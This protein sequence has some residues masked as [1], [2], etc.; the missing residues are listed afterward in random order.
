MDSIKELFNKNKPEKVS[1]YFS[2]DKLIEEAIERKELEYKNAVNVAV[3]SSSSVNGIDQVLRGMCANLDLLANVYVSRY[4]QFAQDILDSNSDLYKFSPEIIFLNI[5]LRTISGDAYFNPYKFNFQERESWLNE[6]ISFLINF[7]D[8]LTVNSKAKIILHNLEVPY[9]SPLTLLENK[10]KFGFIESIQKINQNLRDNYKD[11]KRVFLFDYDSFCGRYGKE[12]IFDE[13]MYYLADIKIK[14]QYL[15]SLCMEYSRFIK[16]STMVAKKCIVLDLDNTLWGGI[17][18]EDGLDGIQLGPDIK[19]RPFMEFQHQILSLYNRGVILAI[20]S[21]N[22]LDEAIDAIRN[23]PYMVLKENHFAAIRINWNDK[24]SNLR[25]LSDEINIGLDSMVFVD[26]DD[27]NRNLV[28]QYLPEV[29]VIDIPKDSSR[30]IKILTDLSSF[31]SLSYTE[32]DAKKGQMYSDEKKR[33]DLKGQ[34]SDLS[35]YL[36]LLDMKMYISVNDRSNAER[37]SQLTQKTNQ[38][39]MTTRRYSE[40]QIQNFIN[41]K[42]IKIY[43]L[44]LADKYGDYGVTGLAMI[45][46]SDTWRIDNLLLSCR[47]L[48]RQVEQ[49]ILAY[50]ADDA[51]KFSQHRLIAEFI[52]T[53]SNKPAIDFYS[54][55]GFQK[56]ENDDE[57]FLE[58][59]LKEAPDYPKYIRIIECESTNL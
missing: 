8:K 29:E 1:D 58:L 24:V 2:L 46:K 57:S 12:N 48:G 32:E 43:S 31:D 49:A 41:S 3:I 15:P 35:D 7:V 5:D 47:V 27:F 37:I 14:T 4:N 38:F 59:N 53:K 54:K 16:A 23:H 9:Y 45:D 20:N 25:S 18:G 40:E 30:C 39:N 19:G 34:I 21:K 51:K 26:D 42:D 52:P 10:Q 6:T 13:K 50:V 11:N 36:K 55:M 44:R 22:N 56:L 33:K 28:K 17:I